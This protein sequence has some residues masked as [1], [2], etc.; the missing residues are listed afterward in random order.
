[1][2]N[3]GMNHHQ[4]QAYEACVE[5][6]KL[7]TST[8]NLKDI[9]QLIV[10]K[11]SQLIEADN[12]SLLLKD[13]KTNELTFDIVVGVDKQLTEKNPAVARGRYRRTGAANRGTKNSAQCRAG[14]EF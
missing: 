8:L 13:D 6:G 4:M 3:S 2:K 7:L 10:L 1:M 14:Y 12:W 11:V 5:V 9:L